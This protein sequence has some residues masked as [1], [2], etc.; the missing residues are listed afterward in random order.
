VVHDVPEGITVAGNPARVISRKQRG[1]YVRKVSVEMRALEKQ[2]F[3]KRGFEDLDFRGAGFREAGLG[4]DSRETKTQ[5]P[6]NFFTGLCVFVVARPERFELPT[7][8]FVAW[9]SIQLSYGRSVGK[10]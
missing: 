1:R 7:T 10:L 8:K 9:C 4:T 3:E 6:V 5:R 2:P